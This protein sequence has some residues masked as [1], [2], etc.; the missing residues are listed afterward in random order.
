MLFRSNQT[1][2]LMTPLALQEIEGRDDVAGISG[3]A[4]SVS[5][6]AAVL[7]ILFI[8]RRYVKPGMIRRAMAIG[9]LVAGTANVLLATTHNSMEYVALFSLFSLVH[10]MM[11][12][13]ANTLIASN[14]SR[15]RRGTGFGIA[16]SAQA[17]ALMVGPMAAAAFGAFS[18]TTGFVALSGV[19]L[20]VA[21]LVL[22]AVH[23]RSEPPEAIP[24]AA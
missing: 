15:D 3:L 8:G 21:A 10:A 17:L 24:A 19:F 14:V 23:D 1:V 18:V 9:T 11:I 16:S 20:L 6:G 13:S 4:F 5:G 2:H 7:G 12:V 22:F